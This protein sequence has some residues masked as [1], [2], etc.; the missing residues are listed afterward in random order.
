MSE[1]KGM[2]KRRHSRPVSSYYTKHQH[3]NYLDDIDGSLLV[4]Q[5]DLLLLGVYP[6]WVEQVQRLRQRVADERQLLDAD[7]HGHLEEVG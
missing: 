5:Q 1:H 6:D 4:A 3:A 7:L 2:A